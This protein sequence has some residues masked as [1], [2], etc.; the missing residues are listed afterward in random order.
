MCITFVVSAITLIRLITEVLIKLSFS[1][2]SLTFCDLV[3]VMHGNS[4]SLIKLDIY[5]IF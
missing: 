4:N 5:V 2:E 3:T 1:T